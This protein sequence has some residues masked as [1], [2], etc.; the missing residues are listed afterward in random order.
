MEQT[1]GKIPFVDYR[2]THEVKMF[3]WMMK[4]EGGREG[5]RREEGEGWEERGWR[6]GEGG[7]RGGEGGGGGRK[8]T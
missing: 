3:D 8:D 2:Y 6:E 7:R 5:G 4:T 1:S